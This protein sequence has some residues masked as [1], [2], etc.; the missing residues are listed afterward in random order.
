M[1]ATDKIHRMGVFC[2]PH[3]G[4]RKNYIDKKQK[5]HQQKNAE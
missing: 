5:H 3:G 2:S 4:H 1:R